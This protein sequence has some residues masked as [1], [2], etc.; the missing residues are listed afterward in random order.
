MLGESLVLACI[1]LWAPGS[2]GG[3]G[4]SHLTRAGVLLCLAISFLFG[5]FGSGAGVLLVLPHLHMYVQF[6]AL[7]ALAGMMMK[8]AAKCNKHAE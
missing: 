3:W 2:G 8:G 4:L 7:D 6:S 1:S 5:P